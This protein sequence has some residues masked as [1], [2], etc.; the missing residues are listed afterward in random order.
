MQTLPVTKHDTGDEQLLLVSNSSIAEQKDQR[1]STRAPLSRRA[2]GVNSL[3]SVSFPFLHDHTYTSPVLQ[4][5]KVFELLPAP[6]DLTEISFT[7]LRQTD[8]KLILPGS[9]YVKSEFVKIHCM[10][11]YK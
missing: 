6:Q 7:T 4:T 8:K 9:F 5:S 11:N 1:R 10:L 2:Y 3:A